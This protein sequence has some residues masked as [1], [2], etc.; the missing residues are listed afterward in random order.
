MTTFELTDANGVW[1]PETLKR[2]RG[3]L[4]AV[5]GGFFLCDTQLRVA[6]VNDEALELL[7]ISREQVVGLP[8]PLDA[9]EAVR[10]DGSPLP[11]EEHAAALALA[12]GQDCGNVIMGL[13]TPERGW[14]WL[15]G[16]ACLLVD[17]ESVEGVAVSFTD[18]TTQRSEHRALSCLG[19]AN[20]VLVTST[21]EA[22]LIVGACDT[23][24]QAGQYAL[25][26]LGVGNDDASRSITILGY[27][28]HTENLIERD[29]SWSAD[30]SAGLGPIGVAMRTGEV[31]VDN[32]LEFRA[33][34]SE[35]PQPA[36][37]ST[38]A[39]M[40]A[41]PLTDELR[42]RAVLTIH[43][44]DPQAFDGPAVAL[45][46]E[47]AGDLG[48][49]IAHHRDAVRLEVALDGTLAVIARMTR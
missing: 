49:G 6:D 12:T 30:V 21:S 27:S 42:P 31:Q 39:S 37:R 1:G 36:L 33:S 2:P 32:D 4:D 14:R 10:E 45:L 5:H 25:A 43:S 28:G 22:E 19:L 44:W 47:M 17:G 15:S 3:L 20:R 24:V 16:D 35:E 18:I 26:W 23:I 38:F 41:I 7:G 29:L 11:P 9:W 48:Y 8:L 40:I 13:R 46:T 34:H